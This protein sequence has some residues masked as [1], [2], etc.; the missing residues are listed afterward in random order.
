MALFKGEISV[1]LM[2]TNRTTRQEKVQSIVL[3]SVA[4]NGT[5]RQSEMGK[6]WKSYQKCIFPISNF[7]AKKS[8]T[9]KD[10]SH[11]FKVPFCCEFCHNFINLKLTRSMIGVA[12]ARITEGMTNKAIAME[13]SFSFSSITESTMQTA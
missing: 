10:M 4:R 7:C 3:I 11:N 12:F 13:L 6:S 1:V 8:H 9:F 5:S 2:V